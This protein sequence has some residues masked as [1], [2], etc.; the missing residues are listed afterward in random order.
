MTGHVDHADPERALLEDPA[1]A[2]L[3]LAERL[4][5]LL[6]LRHVP[7]DGDVASRPTDRGEGERDVDLAA[8]LP[9]PDRVFAADALSGR[10]AGRHGQQL[11]S[12]G[13]RGDQVEV[14]AGD[15]GGGIPE[16]GLGGRVPGGDAVVGGHGQHGVA[17]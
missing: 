8:V 9:D 11:I 5:D 7:G 4:L 3:A 16:H 6:A 12:P 15:V 10:Q 13:E 1:E 14:A 2:F 17:R